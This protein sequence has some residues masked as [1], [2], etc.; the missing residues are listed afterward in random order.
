[1]EIRLF[2]QTDA[3]SVTTLWRQVFGYTEPRN[4]P[5]ISLQRKLA[6]NDDLLLVA[7][8]DGELAGT[9]MG[10]Y[11]GHRGWI[12]SLAVAEHVR[13]RGVGKALVLRMEQLLA[14]R[15]CPKI[16]LQVLTTNAGVVTFYQKLGYNVE[17]RISMG[18]VLS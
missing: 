15:D 13:R 1:M 16:N 5:A 4:D 6:A 8:V 7:L 14:A 2:K 17:Q 10:G 12:Y 11:D 18:K 3:D 9:V